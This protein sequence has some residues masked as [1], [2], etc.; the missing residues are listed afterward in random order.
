M[1][2]PIAQVR[3]ALIERQPVRTD[4]GLFAV[5]TYSRYEGRNPRTGEAVVVPEKHIAF[6][7][8]SS[9]LVA[10]VLGPSAAPAMADAQH[11]QD[12]QFV[13]CGSLYEEIVAGL[14][15]LDVTAVDDASSAWS[16]VSPVDSVPLGD[17][18]ALALFRWKDPELDPPD[19]VTRLVFRPSE[20]LVRALHAAR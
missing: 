16:E 15:R 19:S 10:D 7:L 4:L 1:V 13:D 18:G 17:L 3:R 6:L 9:R 5:R 14:R 12:T 2:D 11:H 8:P 20:E